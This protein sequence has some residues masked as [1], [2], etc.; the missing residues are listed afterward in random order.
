MSRRIPLFPLPD[1]VLLPGTLLPLH[2]FEPRYR[3]LVADALVAERT[4]GMTMLAPGA[5]AAAEAPPIHP[6]GTAGEIVE[7]EELPDGRYNILLEARFRFR[8][9]DEA[10]P[11]PYRVA[12]VEELPTASFREPGEQERL[13]TSARDLFRDV[14]RPLDLPPLPTEA[15]GPER[16]AS[17][18]ALRLRYAPPELQELLETDSLP[19]RF[20]LLRA[21]MLEW[22]SRLQFLAPFRPRQLDP[23]RN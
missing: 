23:R 21:R 22:K 8:V 2:V 20:E 10:P 1:V 15:L 4:I 17:E 16:L 5:D 12:H 18:I 6:V 11:D 9:I 14:A 3:A 19:E 7:S 13:V